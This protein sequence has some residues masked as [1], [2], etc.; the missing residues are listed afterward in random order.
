MTMTELTGTQCDAV[1]YEFR[2]AGYV[3]V[4]PRRQSEDHGFD[5]TPRNTPGAVP[6]RQSQV[7]RCAGWPLLSRPGGHFF[8]GRVPAE[9]SGRDPIL[10]NWRRHR[11]HPAADRRL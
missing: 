9:T 11:K 8:S 6:A 2:A 4:L 5:L 1:Q 10:K 3:K 7:S